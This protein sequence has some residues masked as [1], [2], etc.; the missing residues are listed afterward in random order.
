[1]HQWVV[2][3]LMY[4]PPPVQ[5]S[6]PLVFHCL[7]VWLPLSF[8][9]AVSLL[10]LN[11]DW[12]LLSTARAKENILTHCGI[13]RSELTTLMESKSEEIGSTVPGDC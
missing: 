7:S 5:L 6:I 1:M 4:L 11:P 10:P 13:D 3:M 2:S 9:Q 12:I 8:T